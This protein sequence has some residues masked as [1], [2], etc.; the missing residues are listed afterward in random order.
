MLFKSGNAYRY[1][2]VPDHVHR[3]FISASSHGVYLNTAI[4]NS[5][6]HD[7]LDSVETYRVFGVTPSPDSNAGWVRTIF[8]AIPADAGLDCSI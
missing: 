4:K 1:S 5:Y 7:L 8:H 2:N 3:Q 6:S